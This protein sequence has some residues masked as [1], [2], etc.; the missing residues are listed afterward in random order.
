M[1]GTGPQRILRAGIRRGGIEL[2]QLLRTKKELGG[3]PANVVVAVALVVTIS[4]SVP[5]TELPMGHL[6][7]AGFSAYLL[8]QLGV[9]SHRR[10]HD[11][12][13]GSR[14]RLPAPVPEAHCSTRTPTTR[15][16]HPPPGPYTHH[17]A[18]TP[19]AL[20]PYPRHPT[21]P[22]RSPR[23]VRTPISGYDTQREDCA[24][25]LC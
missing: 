2:R 3:H 19:A 16:V 17:P 25:P 18:P 11:R 6:M 5:G 22:V 12:A 8:F 4:D 15:S 20:C 13:R 21:R 10:R 7:M 14:D 1:R 24:E 23:S 9:R